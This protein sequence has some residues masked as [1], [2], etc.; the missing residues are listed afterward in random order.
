MSPK[1]EMMCLENMPVTQSIDSCA[2]YAEVLSCWNQ[3]SPSMSSASTSNISRI[4]WYHADVTVT[5]QLPTSK[6]WGPIISKADTPHQTVTF[7]LC[8]G[9][10]NTLCVCST[11][12][13]RQFC[14]STYPER[15]KWASSDII[16][17]WRTTAFASRTPMNHLQNATLAFLSISR[18]CEI[19][20]LYGWKLRS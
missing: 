9:F 6:K 13:Y 11:L 3:S 4:V 2:V 7:E 1:C 15:W 20:I 12:Q 5:L 17:L 8:R 16:S 14:L 10:L 19:W 18:S